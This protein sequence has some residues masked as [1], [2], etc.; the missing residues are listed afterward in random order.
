MDAARRNAVANALVAAVEAF[1][2][3]AAQVCQEG[4]FSQADATEVVTELTLAQNVLGGKLAL[5]VRVAESLMELPGAEEASRSPEVFVELVREGRV[6]LHVSSP[7]AD[8]MARALPRCLRD[9]NATTLVQCFRN[10][11]R[12]AVGLTAMAPACGAR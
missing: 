11:Y 12:L 2:W 9:D 1:V 3:N 5:A 4:G 6:P 7:A 8:R 10:M